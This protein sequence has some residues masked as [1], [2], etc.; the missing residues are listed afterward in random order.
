LQRLTPIEIFYYQ[1]PKKGGCFFGKARMD[2]LAQSVSIIGPQGII[3]TA[4]RNKKNSFYD[5]TPIEH[6]GVHLSATLLHHNGIFLLK[7]DGKF[8][9]GYDREQVLQK[10]D[11]LVT[12]ACDPYYPP[13]YPIAQIEDISFCE[14]ERAWLF[15][16]KPL[17]S[18][19]H[20]SYA[21]AYVRDDLRH[22]DAA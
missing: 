19:A 7:G 8:L 9:R 17:Y 4:K 13:L 20:A 5:I 14:I 11:R 6:Q 16:A 18:I 1:H 3:G 2:I 22:H 12:L 15:K 10:G 21:M